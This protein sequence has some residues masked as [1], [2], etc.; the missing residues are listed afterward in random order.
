MVLI[1]VDSVLMNNTVVY[2]NFLL[3]DYKSS[4]VIDWILMHFSD[5]KHSFLEESSHGNYRQAYK[6][7]QIE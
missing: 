2:T 7:L 5:T 1:D 6:L 4:V 3:T